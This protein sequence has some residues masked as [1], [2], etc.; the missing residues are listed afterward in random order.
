MRKKAPPSDKIIL[1]PTRGPPCEFDM[2]DGKSIQ[3]Y[4]STSTFYFNLDSSINNASSFFY[5]Y[6]LIV[7]LTLANPGNSVPLLDLSSD[8]FSCSTA[9][10]A[11]V[12]VGGNVK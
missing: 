5:F 1:V 7:G 9:A 8:R 3:K 6:D 4:L 2:R 12:L 10:A 11:P